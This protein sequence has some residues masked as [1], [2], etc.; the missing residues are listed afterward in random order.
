MSDDYKQP[1]Q[2]VPPTFSLRDAIQQAREEANQRTQEKVKEWEGVQKHSSEKRSIPE[3]EAD[4]PWKKAF[5]NLK[6]KDQKTCLYRLE[7][8]TN[9]QGKGHLKYMEKD[10]ALLLLVMINIAM[11]IQISRQKTKHEDEEAKLRGQLFSLDDRVK[12]TKLGLLRRWEERRDE[13]LSDP[14]TKAAITSFLSQLL[15]EDTIVT[16]STHQ[17]EKPARFF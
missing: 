9:L 7:L 6:P 11:A 5:A 2:G 3:N 8:N 16:D 10:I 1:Q 12:Q 13:L 15:V 4:G 17:P 14:N